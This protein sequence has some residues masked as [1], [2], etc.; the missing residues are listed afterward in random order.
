MKRE[1]K[2][3][4]TAVILGFSCGLYWKDQCRLFNQLRSMA[5]YL[6]FLWHVIKTSMT[7]LCQSVW[8]LSSLEWRTMTDSHP[9]IHFSI[10]PLRSVSYGS[11]SIS[12]PAS[13]HYSYFT[14]L[15]KHR[16]FVMHLLISFLLVYFILTQVLF[17]LTPRFVSSADTFQTTCLAEGGSM[18]LIKA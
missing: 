8:W 17:L 7:H 4:N 10:D 5:F 2:N 6:H 3:T 14:F 16:S 12:P 1:K 9:K 11:P 15:K 13:L 18:R